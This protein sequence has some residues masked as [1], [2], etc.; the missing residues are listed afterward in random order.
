MAGTFFPRVGYIL[1]KRQQTKMEDQKNHCHFP[2]VWCPFGIHLVDE[3]GGPLTVL[4]P[5]GFGRQ[6][7]LGGKNRFQTLDASQ[8]L[9][10]IYLK[11]SFVGHKNE[12][13]HY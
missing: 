6:T 5:I 8:K 2:Y 4:F 7:F 10:Q 13:T 12:V 1:K 11:Q 3:R 9:R